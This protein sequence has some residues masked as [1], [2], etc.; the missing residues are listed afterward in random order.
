M[1]ILLIGA[2]GK[3]GRQIL[4]QGL[5]EGH[6]ITALVRNPDKLREKAPGLEI[7][8]GDVMDPASLDKIMP[9]Q[10]AVL[11]ALGH[12]RFFA[13]TH[14][15][16]K[17]TSNI[18][19][20]MTNSGVRR[21]IC[22]TALGINDSRFRLGLYYTLFTIPFILY[23]YFKDKSLQEKIIEESGLEWTIIRPAQFIPGK[24]RGRYKHGLNEG[25]YILT[26]LISRAD[27]AHFMLRE[28]ADPIYMH[29]KPG[30]SY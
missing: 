27:V 5:A 7:V 24:K 2:T 25:H 30:I 16:S 1:N 28:L 10:D 4:K 14:I 23:F 3:T 26:K 13:K 12:K 21:F 18:I 29:Q 6:S 19:Q 22:I 15:L 17:G 20:S 9:G 11:C 8:K